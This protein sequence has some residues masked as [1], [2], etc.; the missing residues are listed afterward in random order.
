[1]DVEGFGYSEPS[2]FVICQIDLRVALFH[3]GMSSS[4][5]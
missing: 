3:F 1:M 5:S 4:R 2:F